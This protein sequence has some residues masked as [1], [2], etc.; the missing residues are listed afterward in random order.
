MPVLSSSYGE[1]YNSAL[2]LSDIF[3]Y[4]QETGDLL[5]PLH[6]AAD[7]DLFLENFKETNV[8]TTSFDFN[9]ISFGFR[10]KKMYFSFDATS[11][12]SQMI[13]YPGDLMQFLIK[14]NTN[15]Q[16]FDFSGLGME[17]SVRTE[18]AFGVSRAFSDQLTVGIKPKYIKGI[19]NISSTNNDISLYTS[20]EEWIFD[21]E[22]DIQ[23]SLP[24]MSYPLDEN[25]GLDLEGEFVFDSTISGY[26]DV[27]QLLKGNNGFGIDLGIIYSPVQQLELSASLIDLGYITWDNSVHTASLSGSY[28]F[29]A[30]EFD[31][32]DT[33]DSEVNIAD[34]I[35]SKFEFT[36]SDANFKTRLSPKVF[37]GG[38]YFLTKRFDLGAL[39]GIDFP[40]SGIKTTLTLSANWRPSTVWALSA[41]YSPLGGA[42]KTFGLGTSF[43]LGIL[44]LFVITDYLPTSLVTID[45]IPL[46]YQQR[47]Y[48]IRAG[49]NL[50]FGCNQ[51]KKLMKDKPMY[52]SVEY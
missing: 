5:H 42:A 3:W 32:S 39:A 6:R 15:G 17:F 40:A 25:G 24:G 38:R 12:T 35:L 44:N 16:T 9:I 34:T 29:D 41:S 13:S 19:A 52:Y 4:D 18:F 37:V 36:G 2:D 46:P 21:S 33:I 11:R 23:M 47:N 51:T 28:T 7:K 22:M 1:N 10:T 43:R 27:K 14:G 31:L 26:S 20:Y 30:L 48:N 50:V 8:L 45:N 49:L